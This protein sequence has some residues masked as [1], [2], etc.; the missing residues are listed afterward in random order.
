MNHTISVFATMLALGA[1]ALGQ[2]PGHDREPVRQK[3]HAVVPEALAAARQRAAVHNKRVLVALPQEGQDL[4]QMLKRDRTVSRKFLYEFEVVQLD[5]DFDRSVERPAMLVQDAQGKTMA[6][7]AG[8]AFLKDGALRGA[9]LLAAVQ[10][11]FCA[12]LDAEKKLQAAM[13]AAKKSGKNILI[14]FDAPW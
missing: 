14:R 3:R 1:A 11:H 12:P 9:E 8:E 2:E 6:R 7:L 13:V 10:P 5:A 4:A